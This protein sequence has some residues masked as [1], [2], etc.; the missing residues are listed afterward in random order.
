MGCED[1]FSLFAIYSNHLCSGSL[2][3]LICFSYFLV[4]VPLFQPQ[5]PIFGSSGPEVLYRKVVLKICGK[6]TGEHPCRSVISLMFH[7]NFIEI[8]LRHGCSPVNLLH[9]FRTHFLKNTSR[10]LLR[11]IYE[12]SYVFNLVALMLSLT[13][14]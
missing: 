6:L 1:W 10:G 8:T 4:G 7:S 14:E 11:H 3:L 12:I 2:C 9:I 13:F 5:L